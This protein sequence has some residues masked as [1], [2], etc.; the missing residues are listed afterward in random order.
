MKPRFGINAEE[1]EWSFLPIPSQAQNVS[2]YDSGLLGP[3]TAFEFDIGEEEFCRWSEDR[4]WQTDEIDST[5]SMERFNLVSRDSRKLE[6]IGIRSGL[7]Y[8]YVVGDYGIYVAYDRDH[9]RAYF[10]NHTR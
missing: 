5:I 10:F 7:S 4:G 3:Q 1:Q 6:K 2:F 8:S 9:G